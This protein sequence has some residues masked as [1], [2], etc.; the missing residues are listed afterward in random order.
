MATWPP[1]LLLE[2][3]ESYSLSE[4]DPAQ[5]RDLIQG[6]SAPAPTETAL[7]VIA[8]CLT[9]RRRLERQQWHIDRQPMP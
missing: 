3:A 6:P 5:L 9:D 8:Q 1:L 2:I 4:A 7:A